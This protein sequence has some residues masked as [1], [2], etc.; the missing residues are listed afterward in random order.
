VIDGTLGL[1]CGGI[2]PSR[3]KDIEE[4]PVEQQGVD[5]EQDNCCERSETIPR[6]SPSDIEPS[7]VAVGADGERDAQHAER[8]E[9]G[10]L[11]EDDFFAWRFTL[12]VAG[13]RSACFLRIR[14]RA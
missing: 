13:N 4:K 7:R 9:G 2:S 14:A 6:K 10:D 1:E 5:V 12:I 11:A 8:K 3:R